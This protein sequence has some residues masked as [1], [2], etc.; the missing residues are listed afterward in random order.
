MKNKIE[1]IDKKI[2]KASLLDML[3]FA[4]AG[5]ALWVKYGG[6]QPF[7][8]L[9]NDE[10]FVDGMLVVGVVIIVF[11]VFKIVSLGVQKKKLIKRL[12]N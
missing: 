10:N 5:L 9:L 11:S 7:H 6:L 1:E 3:G 4:L 8:P 2:A 12:D